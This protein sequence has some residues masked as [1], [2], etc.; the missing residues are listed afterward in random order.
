MRFSLLITALLLP[1]LS[2]LALASSENPSTTP[3]WFMLDPRQ[4]GIEGTSTQRLRS[5]PKFPKALA[6]I[7]VAVIDTGVDIHHSVFRGKLW[8]N[9]KEVKGTPGIDD[10]GNGVIDDVHG[11]N[12]LGNRSGENALYLTNSSVR[13]IKRLRA[14]PPNSLSI[15]EQSDLNTALEDLA[16]YRAIAESQISSS[17]AGIDAIELLKAHGLTSES[18]SGLDAIESNLPEVLSAKDQA[19]SVFEQYLSSDILQAL[20]RLPKLELDYHLNLDFDESVKIDEAGNNDVSEHD[21][22]HGT[23]VAGTIVTIADAVRIMPIRAVPNGDERDIDIARAVRYAVDHGARIINMSF[24]KRISED[25]N[26]VQDA[27]AYAASHDVLLVHGSGNSGMNLDRDSAQSFPSPKLNGNQRD[28]RLVNHWIE[29]GGSE[30]IR[31]PSLIASSS[32]YGKLSVDIF[33]PSEKISA[34]SPGNQFEE[35]SGTSFAAPQVSGVAALL[36]ARF[37]DAP[38]SRIRDAILKSARKYPNLRVFAPPASDALNRTPFRDLSTTGGL[39]DAFEAMKWL[40]HE[41]RAHNG[42]HSGK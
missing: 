11:W 8:T 32:N 17:K 14:K 23:G 40:I 37:P 36:W 1:G 41:K 22:G 34:P 13:L 28:P 12:L 42:P 16:A 4:D 3:P 25:R 10:D 18:I 20:I 38:A 15:S 26:L 39:L 35:F 24:A 19:R 7:T 9:S 6:Q 5:H 33:A 2:A 30:R 21:S 27:F 31:G 29:V